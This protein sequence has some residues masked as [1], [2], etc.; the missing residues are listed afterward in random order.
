MHLCPPQ[1]PCPGA[2]LRPSLPTAFQLPEDQPILTGPQ[3]QASH[4]NNQWGHLPGAAVRVVTVRRRKA[5][6][7]GKE[8]RP[9]AP[10]AGGSS[11][12]QKPLSDVRLTLCPQPGRHCLSLPGKRSSGRGR[13]WGRNVTA[14]PLREARV[15]SSSRKWRAKQK[16]PV[17]VE[18]ADGQQPASS[19]SQGCWGH[20]PAPPYPPRL[21]RREAWW[22]PLYS[23]GD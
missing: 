8:A 10:P 7:R 4:S 11:V 13:D 12:W 3:P 16:A 2:L 1:A 20:S 21:C 18:E 23:E 5:W 19:E 6:P 22:Y 9:G 14:R 17:S 15:P